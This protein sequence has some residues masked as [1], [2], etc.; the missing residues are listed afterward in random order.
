MKTESYILG[1][2]EFL[3]KEDVS[4]IVKVLFEISQKVDLVDVY[5]AEIKE[6]PISILSKMFTETTYGSISNREMIYLAQRII[7]SN[8]E[9]T[10]NI[11]KGIEAVRECVYETLSVAYSDDKK[12]IKKITRPPTPIFTSVYFWRIYGSCILGAITS[13]MKTKDEYES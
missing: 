2:I 3:I 6:E 10:D 12:A 11:L 5:I 7:Y 13:K 4:N 8:P 1:Q 9:Y